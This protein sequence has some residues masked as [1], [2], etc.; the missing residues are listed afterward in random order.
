VSRFVT[1]EPAHNRVRRSY[2]VTRQ[3][4]P[5]NF[6]QSLTQRLELLR[7]S[8]SRSASLLVSEQYR[9]RA[10]EC[11]FQAESFRDPK[12]RAQMRQL[13]ASYDRKAIFAEKFEMRE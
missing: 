3:A 2:P 12:A 8:R 7:E 13:A 4:N 9:A 10:E 6:R 11:R 5:D 1:F